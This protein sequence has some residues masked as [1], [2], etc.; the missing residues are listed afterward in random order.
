MTWLQRVVRI[1]QSNLRELDAGSLLECPYWITAGL[2]AEVRIAAAFEIPGAPIVVMTVALSE[3]LIN[4]L[5]DV[6]MVEWIMSSANL[7]KNI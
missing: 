6:F 5:R 1:R 7:P 4:F 3:F 2:D